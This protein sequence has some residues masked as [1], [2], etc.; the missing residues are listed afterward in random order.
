MR[1]GKMRVYDGTVPAGVHP[2]RYLGA[3]LACWLCLAAMCS[4]SAF[5]DTVVLR[6]GDLI[7]GT[8]TGV[9]AG[10]LLVRTDY[11]G[12]LKIE[13]RAIGTFTSADEVTTILRNET[14]LFGR[15][16]GD[17]ETVQ[18]LPAGGGLTRTIAIPEL[19]GIEQGRMAEQA[20]RLSGRINVGASSS[21]GNTDVTRLNV[22]TELIA[23]RRANRF[24]LG[25]R[26]TYA[27]DQGRQTESNAIATFKYDRFV[28]PRLY[29]YGSTTF[30]YDPFQDIRLRSTYGAGSGYQVIESQRTNLTVEAGLD[31]VYTDYYDAANQ[32]FP[33]ARLGLRFDH[34]LIDS[35]MQF[36][37]KSEAYG[38]LDQIQQSFVRT[39]TG[40]RFPL[41]DS[42]LAQAQLNYDWDG[43]PQPGR[44]AVDQTVVFS[45]G[46]KW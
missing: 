14:R 15:I 18:I 16:S 1:I 5:A 39:Q 25:A 38:S 43:N 33:A 40:L 13:L 6:N 27:S 3:R 36:F 12:E 42:F 37:H 28:T 35:R 30:E 32:D 31:Y 26:G 2:L 24:T 21:S 9:E 4:W 7:T 46:Y 22:D 44:Q 23:R 20:L 17:S 19:I 34:W 10:R 29:G 45:L 8:I 11:A 41:R